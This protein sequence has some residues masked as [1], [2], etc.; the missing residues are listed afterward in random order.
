MAACNRVVMAASKC[1]TVLS[2]VLLLVS[3][4]LISQVEACDCR[5]DEQN[6]PGSCE[7]GE[8]PTGACC[9]SLTAF[10]HDCLC[11]LGEK[12][13]RFPDNIEQIFFRALIDDCKIAIPDCLQD[14]LMAKD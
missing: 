14:I 5:E 3:M 13:E 9:P 6:V 10:S 8:A 1:A 4:D 11:A 12:L 2:V 7:L